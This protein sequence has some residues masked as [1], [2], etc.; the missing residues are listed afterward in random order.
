[1]VGG[2][3]KRLLSVA[4]RQADIVGVHVRARTDGAGQD[5]TSATREHVARKVGWIR[6]AAGARFEQLELGQN[7][8]SVIV[9]TDR[10][11]AAAQLSGRFGLPEAEI[12][13]SPYFLIGSVEEICEQLV[14][15]REHFGISYITSS[16]RFMEALAPVIAKLGGK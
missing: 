5:W 4:A 13:V 2:G 16:D 6:E 10:S 15:N 3:G 1:M 8:F 11:T 12:L 14:E 7:V 9:T